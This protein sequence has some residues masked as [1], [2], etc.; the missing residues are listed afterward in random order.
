MDV[1]GGEA[2]IFW[3]CEETA[4]FWLSIDSLYLPLNI[5]FGVSYIWKWKSYND[6]E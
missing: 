5:D 6:S 4:D 3:L 1:S 2:S